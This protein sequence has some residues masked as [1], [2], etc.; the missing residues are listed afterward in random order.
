MDLDEKYIQPTL[1]CPHCHEKTENVL[2]NK[3]L[4]STGVLVLGYYTCLTCGKSH[5]VILGELSALC[6][7]FRQAS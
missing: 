6:Q 3:S 4:S 2:D 7:E 5:R 1:Y